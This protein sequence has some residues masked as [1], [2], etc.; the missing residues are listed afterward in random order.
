MALTVTGL[1]C[2]S[3]NYTW[4]LRAPDGRLAICDPGDA[5]PVIAAVEAA[6]GKL[7]LIVLTHHHDDHIA[8]VPALVTRYGS[9][10]MGAKA[11]A[12]RLPPLDIV[13]EPGQTTEILGAPAQVLASDG[14][15]RGH[16]AYHIADG[17]IVLCGDTL[18]SLGC[19]RLI[20][21]TAAEMFDSLQLL[22]ALPPETLVCCGHEYTQSNARFAL[23]VEPLNAALKARAQEVDALRA[24]GKPTVPTT[25]SQELAANPFLRAKDAATL[26]Q[27][28]S[29]KDNFR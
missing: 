2:L 24:E 20:E 16:V 27:I 19:G 22:A 1:P 8:G 26:A 14:H 12:H 10:V 9:K 23:T 17:G 29:A 21:G 4:L 3:D 15:T 5:A 25:I 7:D 11:D 13:V 6:G 28:R 18:F